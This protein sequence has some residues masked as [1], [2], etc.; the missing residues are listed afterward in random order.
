ML[1]PSRINLPMTNI[2]LEV[3]ESVVRNLE[4]AL[5][6][7]LTPRDALANVAERLKKAVELWSAT[8]TRRREPRLRSSENYEMRVNLSPNPSPC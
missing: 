1:G 5:Q 7:Y 3:V 6:D 8:S 4:P 2:P